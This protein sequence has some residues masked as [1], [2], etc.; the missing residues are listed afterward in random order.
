MAQSIDP[1]SP[2]RARLSY[3]VSGWRSVRRGSPDSPIPYNMDGNGNDSVY[4]SLLF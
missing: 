2:V 4:G 1:K 3:V